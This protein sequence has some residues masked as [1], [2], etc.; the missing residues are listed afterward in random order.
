MNNYFR[1]RLIGTR[2]PDPSGDVLAT[3]I[4]N[5]RR[6]GSAGLSAALH[7]RNSYNLAYRHFS[8]RLHMSSQIP[9]TC[10][11]PNTSKAMSVFPRRNEIVMAPPTPA[12]EVMAAPIVLAGSRWRLDTLSA[13]GGMTY[14]PAAQVPGEK[15]EQRR[16]M[17]AVDMM[18]TYGSV[19]PSGKHQS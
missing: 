8:S 5:V 3:S 18:H 7:T 4:S 16:H 19:R 1:S 14:S 11:A 12:H 17:G 10:I 2:S 9:Q 6:S 13:G 15:R